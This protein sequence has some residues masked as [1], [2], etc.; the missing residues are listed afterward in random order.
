MME[1]IN[2]ITC[3]LGMNIDSNIYVKNNTIIDTGTGQN[4]EYL[5]SQLNKAGIKPEDIELIINTHCHFDHVGGNKLFPNAKVAIHKIDAKPLK[6]EGN[7]LT[8][9]L[10]HGITVERH[11][12]DIELEDGD[13]INDFKVIH[14]PG[15]TLGGICLLDEENLI[16]GDTVFPHGSFGRTDIGGNLQDLK[17]SINKLTKLDVEYLLPGHDFWVDNAKKH[18]ELSNQRISQF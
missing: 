16:C 3:I 15:H 6:E 8:A 13:K 14:T 17:E 5:F 18:I 2:G 7:P 4:K 11:D 9:G 1:E 12:V 10:H